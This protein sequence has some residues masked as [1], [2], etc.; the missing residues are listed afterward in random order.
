MGIVRGVWVARVEHNSETVK[1]GVLFGKCAA[2]AT[3]VVAYIN[4]ESS[5]T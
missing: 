1:S 5:S 4:R 2:F 3:D